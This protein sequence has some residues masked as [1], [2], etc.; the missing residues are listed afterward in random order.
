MEK[1]LAHSIELIITCGLIFGVLT[2]WNKKIKTTYHLEKDNLAYTLFIL[3]QLLAIVFI[4]VEGI[5]PQNGQI[6]SNMHPFK[7]QSAKFWAIQGVYLIGFVLV[8]ILSLVMTTIIS[9]TTGFIDKSIASEI[10]KVNWQSTLIY[11]SILIAISYV[12]SLFVL[13]PF[14]VEWIANN[15]Q[16]VPLS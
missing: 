11:G 10:E 16:F 6:M 4:V 2:Y 1:I 13:R 14:L 15:A 5:D 7:E 9:I 8:Y 3:S 12:F